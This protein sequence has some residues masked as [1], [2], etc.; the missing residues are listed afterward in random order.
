GELFE[1]DLALIRVG[2]VAR[3]EVGA[4]PGR[5]FTGRVSFVWPVVDAQSRTGRVRVVL[6]NPHGA[7]KPGMYATLF[8]DAR[9]GADALSVP[10]EAVVMT[11]ERNLVFV[12]GR[13]GVLEP[14]E[15]TLGGRAGDR[16]EILAGLK[17]GERIVASANFLVD[18]ESRLGAGKGMAAMPGMN[19]EKGKQEQP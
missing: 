4:Y 15:V 19:M 16:L 11:G 14:H 9:V 17:E 3:V 8:F 6:P 1:Q 12:V 18:A 10:A 2:G 7:L 5:P 13:E